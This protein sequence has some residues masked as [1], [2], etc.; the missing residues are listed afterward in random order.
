MLEGDP[1]ER[2]VSVCKQA[3]AEIYLSGPAA[4]NYLREELFTQAGIQV[5]WMNYDSYPEYAQLYPPF[6]HGVSVLDLLFNVG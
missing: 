1:T 4:K 5:E 2:L 3:G 6:E